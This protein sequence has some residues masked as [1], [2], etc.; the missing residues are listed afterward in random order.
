MKESAK[1]F[2]QTIILVTHDMD[3]AAQADRIITI[4]DGR[5]SSIVDS[6]N[7]LS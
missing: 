3:I 2:G 7:Y 6:E 1:R 4:V 5:I